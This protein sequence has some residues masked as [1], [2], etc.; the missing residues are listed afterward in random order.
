MRKIQKKQRVCIFSIQSKVQF[1][2]FL[3]D[4]INL[5]KTR[6][7]NNLLDKIIIFRLFFQALGAEE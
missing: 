5:T 4:L 2:Y 7:E 6:S 3:H 1:K